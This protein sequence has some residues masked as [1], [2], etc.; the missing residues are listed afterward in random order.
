MAICPALVGPARAATDAVA[1]PLPLPD[2][3]VVAETGRPRQLAAHAVRAIARVILVV[4]ALRVALL[5]FAPSPNDQR[6]AWFV[7][8]SQVLEDPFRPLM[9]TV[10]MDPFS[11]S[12]LDTVA[13]TAMLGYALLE[14]GLV[15]GLTWRPTPS[16]PL[17]PLPASLVAMLP[18]HS[19][20]PRAAPPRIR[21]SASRA[22]VESVPTARVSG[23]V[24]AG[25]R[26]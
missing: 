18:A 23:H 17:P 24:H 4:L 2:N 12:I 6:V 3:R 26:S 10:F 16:E 14:A 13:L 7:V 11:G 19:P 8:G 20:Q 1:R 15:W 22:A 5:L 9:P 25:R 21:L